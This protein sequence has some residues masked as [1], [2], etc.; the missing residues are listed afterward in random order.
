MNDQ[1]KERHAQ[2]PDYVLQYSPV[3]DAVQ[4]PEDYARVTLMLH[5]PFMRLQ[6]LKI[7]NGRR[8]ECMTGTLS[9][10]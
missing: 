7:I 3:N 8:F 2:G 6:D 1:K 5:H 9:T 10:C 4:Q